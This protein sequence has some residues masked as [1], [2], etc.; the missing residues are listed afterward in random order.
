[1]INTAIAVFAYRRP[2]HLCQVL[3]ALRT[4]LLESPLPVHVFLDGPRT[5]FDDRAVAECGRVIENVMAGTTFQI[6]Q[7]P[8]NLGLYRSLTQG[9]SWILERYSSIIVLEDDILTAPSFLSYMLAGLKLY[10]KEPRVSSIHGYLP[11]IKALMPETFFLRGADCW[12]WATWANRW[13][14]FRH[15]AADMAEEIRT[16]GWEEEFN[17]LGR[18]DYLGLLDQQAAGQSNSWAIC[19][20]ASCFLA[21]RL[22]L[23]PGRSLVRNIGLDGSGEHCGASYMMETVITTQ[24]IDSRPIPVHVDPEVF[25]RFCQ[26][27]ARPQTWR[28]RMT[29]TAQRIQQGLRALIQRSWYPTLRLEGPFES[30]EEA[31]HRS[32]GYDEPIVL[33]TVRKAVQ[34]VLEGRAL[35]ERDGTPFPVRPSHLPLTEILRNLLEPGMHVVDLGAGLGGTWINHCELFD[36]SI[37]Y[38]VIEQPQFNQAGSELASRYGLP[39][40][41]EERIE[42]VD[43][44][45]DLVI[46]SCVLQYLP[47]P[48]ALLQGIAKL[49]PRTILIDRTAFIDRGPEQWWIQREPTYY[50]KPIS[51]PICPLLETKLLAHLSGYRTIH[52]WVSPMDPRIPVHRGLWLQRCP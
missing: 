16:R 48:Y 40:R 25:S 46:L 34:E 3:R 12:G 11:A 13:A 5:P 6:H 9:V 41:F 45:P 30:H 52:R 24:A 7:S 19:W 15:D 32:S 28:P 38:T 50:S 8:D 21:E 42:D 31:R 20:H 33:A 22:T 47:D 36:A 39:I 35:Y 37:C 27:F 14:L 2:L 1:M 29:G 23:H 26:H 43:P 4:Q 17:L 51:Y 10:E 49:K 18:Y 44:P